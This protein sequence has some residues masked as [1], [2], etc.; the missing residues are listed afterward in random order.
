MSEPVHVL[1]FGG[2]DTELFRQLLID[3]PHLAPC[4]QALHQA[5]KTYVH[6]SGAL[7]FVWPE[8]VHSI[9]EALA[10]FSLHP[11]NI[12]ITPGLEY[13]LDEV[14]SGMPCR[15]CPSEKRKSRSR[16]SV[17]CTQTVVLPACRACLPIIM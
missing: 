12:V 4:R 10:G 14:L 16:V 5:G 15:K 7:V 3:G 9:L 2:G 1:R 6:S 17:T 8:Q 13:L 11:F